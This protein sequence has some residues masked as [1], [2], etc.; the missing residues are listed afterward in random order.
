M[1]FV[2]PYWKQIALTMI[3]GILKFSIPLLLPLLLKYVIDNLLLASLSP[4]EK[5]EKLFYVIT[6]A[7]FLFTVIRYPVEYYRQYFAQ[8][9]ASRVLFDIRNRLFDHLQ[10][11][12]MS[13]YNNN[14]VGQIISRVINDVEQTKEFVITGMMNIWLDFTTISIAVGIMFWMDFW[15]TVIS[16]AI[17][18]IY[19]VTVKYFFKNLRMFTRERS[20]ALAELQGHLH[21]RIQ[22]IAVIRAFHLED[23]EQKQ[24][25]V[26]NRRFLDKAL[27]HTSWTAKTFASVNTITDIA[28]IIVI[29]ISAYQVIYGQLSIGEMAAFF[30][31]LNQIYSPV[32]RLVNSSTTLT[33]AL[34]SMDRVFEFLDES[35]EIVDQPHAV[36][37]ES[38]QGKVEFSQV[39]FRY[40]G[41]ERF[42]LEELNLTIP[43]GKKVAIVGPSGGGKSS[44]I[45]LI[46]RFYD[47][48]AGSVRIDDRDVREFTLQSLRRQIGM[49]LQ[50]PILFSGTVEENIR[51]GKVDAAFEE[52]VEAAK[53]ANAHD[54][55]M[56][57]PDGYQSEIGERGVKLSGGQKQRIALARVFLKNPRILILDEATSA[58]DLQS[59]HLVQESIERLA[60]NRTTIIVAHRLSTITDADLIVVIDRGRVVEQGTHA[61]LMAKN[62][63]YAELYNVQN[64]SN[65]TFTLDG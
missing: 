18:P 65:P 50:D 9:A 35:Y 6:A 49:V 17:F 4:K 61:E 3:V 42:V 5:I 19:G 41:T 2:K 55:I 53:A 20:Q 31:Y 40:P 46:P 25:E 22:G 59:E 34:A 30:G 60:K 39:S 24:F 11:L 43:A 48:V 51:L 12:S 14:K 7:F 63:L 64:L 47:V 26:Q 57:L 37:V 23:Y 36:D 1:Q 33:Q 21:E 56:S 29:A 54:F 15:M 44:L 32:R 38:V 8:W 62:G 52:I 10:K 58:L 13:Y 27:Q 16:L 45:S 28:P